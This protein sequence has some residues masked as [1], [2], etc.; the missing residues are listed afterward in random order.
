M[1]VQV[2]LLIFFGNNI[3]VFHSKVMSK[4]CVVFVTKED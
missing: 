2:V 3:Y 1:N 4:L